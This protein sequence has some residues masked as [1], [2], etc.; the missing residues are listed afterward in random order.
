MTRQYKA[1]AG[2]G[3]DSSTALS[4]FA[5]EEQGVRVPELY[6]VIVFFIPRPVV[7]PGKRFPLLVPEQIEQ[8]VVADEI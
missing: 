6:V 2:A 1:S 8:V 5:F 4:R 7:V 3:W